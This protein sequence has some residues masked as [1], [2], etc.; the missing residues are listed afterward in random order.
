MRYPWTAAVTAL[1][2]LST[3]VRAADKAELKVLYAGN[4]DSARGK[5]F[6]SFLEQHFTRV[7]AVELGKF[8]ESDAKGHDVVLFDWTS[9]YPRDKDGKINHGDRSVGM[10]MPPAPRLSRNFDRPAVLIG[11]AGGQVAGGQQL[12]IDWL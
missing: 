5:D 1:A 8:Q 11:A 6:T 12:K 7:T 9:I 2:L 10:S 4:V 3:P